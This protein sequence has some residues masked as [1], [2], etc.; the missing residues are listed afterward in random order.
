MAKG[1]L[2]SFRVLPMASHKLLRH[3]LV[4]QLFQINFS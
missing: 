4:T 1:T 2:R 3:S